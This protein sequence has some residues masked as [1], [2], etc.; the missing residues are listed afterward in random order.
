MPVA[1]IRC[2]LSRARHHFD[3]RRALEVHGM[4]CSAKAFAGALGLV[5]VVT[6]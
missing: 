5:L 3:G 2:F 4:V 1:S 6:D